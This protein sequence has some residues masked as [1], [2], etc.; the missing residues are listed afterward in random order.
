MR[1]PV[2][3]LA[4]SVL[5]ACG[6]SDRAPASEPGAST[7]ASR[8]P[9]PV[10]LRVPRS[11]GRVT[12]AIL[13]RLD[14]VVWRSSEPAPAL[15]RVLAFDVES[16]MLAVIDTAG[17]PTRIDLRLGTVRTASKTPLTALAAGQGGTFFGLAADGSVTRLTPSG[18]AWKLP[19]RV[20]AQELYPQRDGSVLAAGVRGGTGYVWRL[21]PPTT[22]IGDS[23]T[24]AGG[25]RAVRTGSVER[26]YF[27]AGQ[28]LHGVR[29]RD[30][31][32]VPAVALDGPV[33][34]IV[35]TPS[36]DRMYVALEGSGEVAVVDR[37]RDAVAR[38]ITLPGEVRE[39]RI[40][41]LGR[42]LLARPAR[43]DSAWVVAVGTDRVVGSVAGAWRDDLPLVMPDG[44]IATAT[45]DDV[46]LL[47]GASLQP[48]DTV[49]KG[50]ADFWHVV[51]WNGFRPRSAELDK[52][53]TFGGGERG[54]DSAAADTSA[55]PA[56][57]LAPPPD[58]AT[59][60]PTPPETTTAPRP[61][62]PTVPPP[63]GASP[64]EVALAPG[65]GYTVQFAAA[66]DERE[67]RAVVRRVT[68]PGRPLRV[69]PATRGGH[70]FYRVVSGPF[71]SRSDAERAART[72][73]MRFWVYEGV[74]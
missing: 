4:A 25:G 23:A 74:P 69:V 55:L 73:G 1:P 20:P 60:A 35:A 33:R 54:A 63:N 3:L 49:A 43:G 32:A 50:A 14:S 5:A 29:S 30:L 34:A 51:L 57:T 53:V 12:A 11:G 27:A 8:G 65:E 58:T 42:Y 68:M 46:T 31:A 17:R 21:R 61:A 6:R 47:D 41:A 62:R 40:D 64:G 66:D 39:L 10:L 9:D 45:G 7:V 56:D 26:V 22:R 16:G 67:A 38:S 71:A 18:D 13:P 70:R 2:I 36:G 19:L 37:F 15:A 52:P 28:E 48:R 44:A 24:V 72:T 59:P